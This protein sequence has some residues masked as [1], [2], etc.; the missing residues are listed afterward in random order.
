MSESK[1]KQ[2]SV[3]KKTLLLAFEFA[4]II[5]LPLLILIPLGKWLER[6]YDSRLWLIAM[7]FLA[8]II[9]STWLLI[10]IKDIYKDLKNLK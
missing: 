7:L 2:A 5:I 3:Q 1:D 10:K 4:F 9:S 8:F 6:T